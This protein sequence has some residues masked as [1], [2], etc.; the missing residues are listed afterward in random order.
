MTEALDRLLVSARMYEI[1]GLKRLPK[2]LRRPALAAFAVRL[3]AYADRSLGASNP[4]LPPPR[5]AWLYTVLV[6]G[7]RARAGVLWGLGL[8]TLEP[9]IRRQMQVHGQRA[10]G[11]AGYVETADAEDQAV[12][13]SLLLRVLGRSRASIGILVARLHSTLPAARS[14]RL[15]ARWLAEAGEAKA[16]QLLPEAP[17]VPPAAGDP[18]RCVPRRLRYGVVV[19]TMFDTEIFRTSIRSLL[20]SDYTG[21]IVVVEEGNETSEACRAFCES[22]GV[23]YIK[24]PSWEGCAA[25]INLGVAALAPATDIV[26]SSHNDVL[27]PVRWLADLDA[28]WERVWDSDKVGLLNLNYIQINARVDAQLTDL[29]VKGEYDDL[30]WVLRAMREIPA[31]CDQVQDVQVKAGEMPFGLARDPWV[32]WMPDLRQQTG[33]YSVVASFPLRLWREIGGFDPGLVYAFDL[34]F[35]HHAMQHRRWALF[36]NTPPVIHLKSSDTEHISPEKMAQVGTR[37]LT[38][39]YDGFHQKYGWHIEHFLNLF[40]SESTVVHRDAI[41]R[42]ANSGRFED[43]DFVFDDFAER[44][45]TRRLGNCEL[46]WCRVR[47]QC[48]HV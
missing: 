35:L 23:R 1:A 40:F 45:R 22:V 11:V 31:V 32:D 19:L 26:L 7:L 14:S 33:R 2:L 48:P 21:E 3:F 10:R 44:L 41:V 12:R 24:S 30:L 4:D 16:A 43:V 13:I 25:G 9:Q 37:F 39:T 18:P 6:V 42:A 20:A 47:A 28:A 27:W 29:F 15:L 46:T 36:V 5:L 8:A 17:E 34:Q 38:S